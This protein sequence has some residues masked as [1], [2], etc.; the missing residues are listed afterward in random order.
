MPLQLIKNNLWGNISKLRITTLILTI[1]A[2]FLLFIATLTPSWQ[3]AEDTDIHR[4]IQSGLWIYCPGQSQCWY[5]F[6]GSS[7]LGGCLRSFKR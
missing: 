1:S 5:I 2:E 6:R 7:W 3:V 4:N